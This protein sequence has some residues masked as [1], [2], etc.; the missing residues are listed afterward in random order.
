MKTQ[1]EDSENHLFAEAFLFLLFFRRGTT[2]TTTTAAAKLH[3]LLYSQASESQTIPL[4]TDPITG[5][6]FPLAVDKIAVGVS[7]ETNPR[8]RP[9]PRTAPL[10]EYTFKGCVFHA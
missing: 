4:I 6:R 2:T 3:A 8:L 5:L 1:I 9:A 10:T 7:S